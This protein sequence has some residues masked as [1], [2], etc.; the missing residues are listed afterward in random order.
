MNLNKENLNKAYRTLAAFVKTSS[1]GLNGSQIIMKAEKGVVTFKFE[2]KH[3]F[4]LC[5][6][7]VQNIAPK[8]KRS[9]IS[10][11]KNFQ[12][13]HLRCCGIMFY[14]GHIKTGE[15]YYEIPDGS[16]QS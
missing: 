15:R 10:A 16:Q 8:K 9:Q 3:L 14:Q 11:R 6:W 1:S 5:V 7:S 2:I 4:I 13:L 12:D